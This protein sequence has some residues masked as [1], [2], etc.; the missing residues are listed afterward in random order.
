MRN[1]GTIQHYTLLVSL[2]AY[3]PF[4]ASGTAAQ[5][6]MDPFDAIANN[7]P[8]KLA[9]YLDHGGNPNASDA[10]GSLLDYAVRT[11]RLDLVN[12]LLQHA[13]DVNIGKGSALFLAAKQGCLN[14]AEALIMHGANVN[15]ASAQGLP[16]VAA[17]GMK[18]L[19]VA[20]LLLSKGATIP[21]GRF[22]LMWAIRSGSAEMTR[23]ALAAN[24][25]NAFD[26]N[27]NSNPSVG[28]DMEEDWD[29]EP[30]VA[31]AEKPEVLAVLLDAHF[32]PNAGHG[33]ALAG[34]ASSF[35]CDADIVRVLLSHGAD[36]NL[37]F[38]LSG[39]QWSVP[40]VLAAERGHA[41]VVEALLLAHADPNAV[42]SDGLSALLNG[43]KNRND[44]VVRYLLEGKADPNRPNKEGKTPLEYA[45]DE[46]ILGLV[47]LLLQHG[48]DPDKGKNLPLQTAVQKGNRDIV[49]ALI[50][51]GANVNLGDGHTSLP[52]IAAENRHLDVMEFLMSYGAPMPRGRATLL[53]AVR[54]GNAEL[55]RKVLAQNSGGDVAALNLYEGTNS[56]GTSLSESRDRRPL[57]AQFAKP[58]V[59]QVLLESHFDPNAAHGVAL[60]DASTL[61]DTDVVNLLL[62]YGADP[63]LGADDSGNPEFPLIDAAEQGYVEVVQTLLR[64]HANPN[65]VDSDGNSALLS[66]SR[67]GYDEVAH[68]LLQGGA[69][70]NYPNRDGDTPL[71]IAS[72]CGHLDI[73][74][75][76]LAGGANV[77][78]KNKA[79]VTALLESAA[80][81]SPNIVAML[82]AQGADQ[83]ATKAGKSAIDMATTNGNL[84]A[85]TVLRTPDTVKWRQE[86]LPRDLG[87]SSSMEPR[88]LRRNLLDS[89]IFR[90]SFLLTAVNKPGQLLKLAED[91]ESELKI[92]IQFILE[93]VKALVR[94]RETEIGKSMNTHLLP[95]HE[96]KIALEDS[97]TAEA[98]TLQTADRPA[99]TIVI[100]VKLLQAAVDSSVLNDGQLNFNAPTIGELSEKITTDRRKIENLAYLSHVH[101]RKG[102]PGLLVSSDPQDNPRKMA[103]DA[104][105]LG[106]FA[107]KI[108]PAA[109]Q[110]YGIV[111]FVVAHELG[112]V[113]LGHGLRDVSCFDRETA[114]DLF[115]ASVLGESLAAMSIREK[116][117]Y[118]FN[119]P[120]KETSV[121]GEYLALDPE[122]LASYT[123]FSLFF[124]RSYELAGFAPSSQAC[125][126][127]EPSKRLQ[128]SQKAVDKIASSIGDSMIARLAE[129][130]D[131]QSFLDAGL[132]ARQRALMQAASRV[133]AS[134][135]AFLS[136]VVSQLRSKGYDV[137]GSRSGQAAE[138]FA[139]KDLKQILIRVSESK[140]ALG[141]QAIN[142]M[143]DELK[144]HGLDP[145]GID[146]VWIVA[147][148]PFTPYAKALGRKSHIRLIDGTA[149]EGNLD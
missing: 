88:D 116:Q 5:E 46:D 7:Q 143:F 60:A 61:G 56:S 87:V 45:V 104:N 134:N 140:E 22:A 35:S 38:E 149:L 59:L 141:N 89:T 36:P 48:A 146:E 39:G 34:C 102:M 80:E 62:K 8:T 122:D 58:D 148:P 21:R 31:Q 41:E 24:S 136:S 144:P 81:G 13:A 42:D 98:Y 103:R 9:D 27:V 77:N 131:L 90:D 75:Y 120:T 66:A 115:A 109:V 99:G 2:L 37:A 129:R 130:K 54:S 95:V 6:A 126:Y 29:N 74:R 106:G 133:G 82:L 25:P 32:D 119:A 3:L 85:L 84:E 1:L 111:L 40:L 112:H 47:T 145:F 33:M 70:P 63:N 96:T 72:R 138:L 91:Q 44:E 94:R 110:Y 43:L 10:G 68:A 117:V 57:V 100:D 17:M 135:Y 50:E 69:D 93:F 137:L 11:D 23:L 15:L 64:A 30:L 73:V 18:H 124:D 105:E 20:H 71:I 12:S 108:F 55:V 28:W 132:I 139:R 52:L 16:L 142:R 107:P 123:G 125:V 114:A 4:L 76:L 113:A 147:N 19:D 128:S 127:P 49:G 83:R 51:H 65:V 118:F 67:E 121:V 101:L 26:L 79:G 92:Q 86:D 14:I 78:A 53:A 97:G